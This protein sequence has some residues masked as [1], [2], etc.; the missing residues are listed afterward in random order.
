MEL[1]RQIEAGMR[2][3]KPDPLPQTCY[4][5]ML[6]CWDDVPDNRPR[7][8]NIIDSLTEL[9]VT[10]GTDPLLRVRPAPFHSAPEQPPQSSY[11]TIDDATQ[12]KWRSY[13]TKAASI[14][15]TLAPKAPG[16]RN[17]GPDGQPIGVRPQ[18]LPPPSLPG[19]PQ[20]QAP[21]RSLIMCDDVTR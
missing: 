3:P 1:V 18:D 9:V 14:K 20:R 16:Y 11:R 15:P 19:E 13:S 7:F 6:E 4:N 8:R 21:A 2:L 10:I 5:L 17:I 12:A